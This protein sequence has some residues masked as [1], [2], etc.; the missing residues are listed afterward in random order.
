VLLRF[1]D[2]KDRNIVHN[3]VTLGRWIASQGFPSGF[4]L[5]PNTRVWREADIEAWLQSRP[6]KIEKPPRGFTAKRG[7]GGAMIKPP[8]ENVKPAAPVGSRDDGRVSNN[9]HVTN[10]YSE[11]I[12]SAQPVQANGRRA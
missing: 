1:S 9:P 6:I 5:G 10:G 3:H 8:P 4:M 2:L 7:N 11:S 12:D